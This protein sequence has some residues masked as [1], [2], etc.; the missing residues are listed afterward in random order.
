MGY[1]PISDREDGPIEIVRYLF[2]FWML[3]RTRW[4]TLPSGA[5]GETTTQLHCYIKNDL[6]YWTKWKLKAKFFMSKDQA[7][8]ALLML[9]A[10][11]P[12]VETVFDPCVHVQLAVTSCVIEFVSCIL[13]SPPPLFKLLS[14]VQGFAALLE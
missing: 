10:N 3:H 8:L 11:D 9:E 7:A 13:I 14:A 5:F 1:T 12:A 6:K 4:Y 2:F